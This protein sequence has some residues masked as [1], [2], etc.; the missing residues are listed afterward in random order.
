MPPPP[1][2]CQP[3]VFRA[4]SVPVQSIERDPSA[5]PES[6][7]GYGKRLNRWEEVAAPFTPWNITCSLA[8][9]VMKRN[10]KSL[11]KYARTLGA[12]SGLSLF[13]RSAVS[14]SPIRN[15]VIPFRFNVR[16]KYR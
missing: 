16:A 15:S 14:S 12:G 11:K 4:Q 3:A 7:Q 1:R 6:R 5:A 2:P 10:A 13:K 8:N 9:L